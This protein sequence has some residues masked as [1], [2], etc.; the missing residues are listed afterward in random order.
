MRRISR[1]FVAWLILGVGLILLVLPFVRGTRPTLSSSANSDQAGS[2]VTS[3]H[4]STEEAEE[5]LGPARE[6]AY[7]DAWFEPHG[8]ILSQDVLEEVWSEIHAVPREEEERTIYNHWTLLGPPGIVDWGDMTNVYS[9]RILDIDL[10]SNVRVAA[11]SGGLWEH[12]SPTVPL[13]DA[14]PS[15]AIGSF[16]NQ[17]G[18]GGQTI[19]IGTGEPN[20]R[21]GRGIWRT[22][23]RGVNWTRSTMST[24]DPDAVYRVRFTPDNANIVH[25]ATTTGYYR[26]TDGG[27]TW[28]ATHFGDC[29]DVAV[30][31]DFLQIV[32]CRISVDC[33]YLSIDR[34]LKWK[35]L[36]ASGLPTKN[37]GITAISMSSNPSYL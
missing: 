33:L 36:K 7:F 13:S 24:Y 18:S 17:P 4:A 15:L 12:G 30:S 11:A 32:Y 6:R 9:G 28:N 25:A 22:T 26:S 16:A 19:V 14:V 21:S 8:A 31:L 34:V 35:K 20:M 2:L 10:S 23:N 3:V 27:M 29:T 37:I 1:G 5:E